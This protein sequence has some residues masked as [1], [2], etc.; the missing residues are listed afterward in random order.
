MGRVDKPLTLTTTPNCQPPGQLVVN[1]CEPLLL[2][3]DSYSWHN[4]SRTYMMACTMYALTIQASEY[5]SRDHAAASCMPSALISLSV[6]RNTG[7]LRFLTLS[8]VFFSA[9]V[10]ERSIA[11]SLSVRLCV[12]LYASISLELLDRSLRNFLCRSPVAVVRSSS[13]GVAICYA[14]PM[15]WTTSRLAVVGR[16]A[17]RGDTGAMS[18]V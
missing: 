9:P 17:M 3:S 10:G 8:A 12:R 4:D 15:L 7:P 18:D 13:A 2:R 1:K 14:L 5:R 6:D 16:M 11:V